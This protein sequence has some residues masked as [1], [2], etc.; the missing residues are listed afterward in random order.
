MIIL[1]KIILGLIVM[2]DFLISRIMFIDFRKTI[3]SANFEEAPIIAKIKVRIIFYFTF[4]AL[5]AFAL[6]L[7]FYIISPMQ[8]L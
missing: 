4:I 5:I 3:K 1:L 7:G 8:I 6:L 2:L